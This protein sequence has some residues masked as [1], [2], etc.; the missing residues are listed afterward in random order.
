MPARTLVLVG[1]IPHGVV[2]RHAYGEDALWRPDCIGYVNERDPLRAGLYEPDAH[3]APWAPASERI[4]DHSFTIDAADCL[5]A[6]GVQSGTT[7]ALLID[8]IIKL[9]EQL[10][11]AD[12]GGDLR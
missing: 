2:L 4:S 5:S 10:A 6:Y 1:L 8:E 7:L 9:R 3:Y 11:L 12:P